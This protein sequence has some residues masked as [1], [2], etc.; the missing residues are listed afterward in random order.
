MLVPVVV[1]VESEVPLLVMDTANTLLGSGT[2]NLTGSGTLAGIGTGNFRVGQTNTFNGAVNITSGGNFEYGVAGAVDAAATF[3]IGNE[4]E[5]ALQGGS[6]V[7][8]SNAITVSGGTN[9]VLSF[10]NGNGGDYTGSI[11]LNA[12]TII[13]LRDWYNTA[14]AHN[15][16]ISGI[17]SGSGDISTT[18][19]T[20]GTATLTVSGVNT[21]TGNTSI[22]TGTTFSVGGAGQLGS[23]SYAGNIAN[24]GT[25]NHNS[26]ANQSLSG[27]ISGAGTV[28]KTGAGTLVLAGSNTYTGLTTVNGGILRVNGSNTGEGGY[29]VG[30]SGT[31][32]GTGSLGSG[33]VDVSGVLSPGA[34]V[35]TLSGGTVNFLTG[36]TFA[37]EIDSSVGTSSGADLQIISGDLTLTGTVTLTMDDLALS[38]TA[39]TAGTTFSLFNYSGTWNSGIFTFGGNAIADDTT[40]TAGLNTWQI[41][42]NAEDGGENFT[43]EYLGGSDSFVNI[44]AVPEPASAVL[45]GLGLL[46]LLRRRRRK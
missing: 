28:T 5:F 24:A 23:G 2:L 46:A 1:N 25:L 26:S 36:S 35:Q 12:N 18:R 27:A 6:A 43:G 32:G 29:S 33:A 13:G 16:T 30:A 42:Y 38:D 11:T 31:L 39:Y 15:G 41:D 37:Y 14:V 3:N 10:E 22:G 40:F 45:G 17:I 9:S 19:G 21:Y 4:G 34:S 8:S 44:T 20:T 7:S